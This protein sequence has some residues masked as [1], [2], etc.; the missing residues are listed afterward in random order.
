MRT[1]GTTLSNPTGPRGARAPASLLALLLGLHLD[2]AHL[3]LFLAGEV[4]P[5]VD[6][7]W[8]EAAD[9]LGG[10]AF[11]QLVAEGVVR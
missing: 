10:H 1:S 8:R 6:D 9:I 2:L 7:H 3:G 11:E 5:G 4:A